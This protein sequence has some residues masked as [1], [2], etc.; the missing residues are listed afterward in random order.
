MISAKGLTKR[1]RQNGVFFNAVDSVTLDLPNRGLV[2]LLGESGAGKTTLLNLLAL[3]D[4]PTEGKLAYGDTVITKKN[5]A[6][7]RNQFA[8]FVTQEKGLIEDLTVQENLSFLSQNQQEIIGVLSEVGIESKSGS[9]VCDLSGGEKKRVSIARC[10]LKKSICIF[11]DEPTADLDEK[12]AE[13]IFRL[14]KALAKDHLVFVSTHDA[15]LARQYGEFIVSMAHGKIIENT[16][17]KEEYSISRPIK[18]PDPKVPPKTF[19]SFFWNTIHFKSSRFWGSFAASSL[20]LCLFC[21]LFSFS[22]FQ[23]K[24]AFSSALS[25]NDISFVPILEKSAS[26]NS[27]NYPIRSNSIDEAKSD[28]GNA[29]PFLTGADVTS[30][31]PVFVLPYQ[32]GMHLRG[33]TVQ[34]PQVGECVCSSFLSEKNSG[35]LTLDL[36]SEFSSSS[37]SLSVKQRIGDFENTPTPSAFS[38]QSLYYETLLQ[39]FTYVIINEDQFS[40]AFSL[41]NPVNIPASDFLADITTPNERYFKSRTKYRIF[42]NAEISLGRAPEAPGEIA[43][44]NSYLSRSSYLNQPSE[45]LGKTFSYRDIG[46]GKE[47]SDYFRKCIDFSAVFGQVKIVGITSDSTSDVFLSKEDSMSLS[48]ELLYFSGGVLTQIRNLNATSST[49]ADFHYV[50]SLSAL[51]CV[52]QAKQFASSAIEKLLPAV[53]IS[54]LLML[55]VTIFTFCVSLFDY[56]RQAAASLNLCGIKNSSL[57]SLF[58]SFGAFLSLISLCLGIPL[59]LLV[60]FLFNHALYGS[61]SVFFFSWLSLIPALFVLLFAVVGTNA[62]CFIRYSKTPLPIVFR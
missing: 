14:A 13:G 32:E 34:N 51:E 39:R 5:A 42:E 19:H 23:P 12:N 45:I 11:M 49:L 27:G 33:E 8:S 60:L 54:L 1:Y 40:N 4:A 37:I 62:I 31:L 6:H 25:Q 20:L 57:F 55:L 58:L 7:L 52:Y 21:S 10:L 17:P 28:F 59:A 2:C 35:N 9:K 50:S 22:N 15:D 61:V 56:R 46:V 38:N 36:N 44:S 53:A 3:L 26:P 16:I 43:V 24:K 47:T 30:N 41:S 18:T 29:T 48:K